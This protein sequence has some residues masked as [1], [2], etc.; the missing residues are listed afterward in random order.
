MKNRSK[1]VSV[2]SLSESRLKQLVEEGEI[3]AG[4]TRIEIMSNKEFHLEEG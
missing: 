2:I 1:R 4:S 3:T